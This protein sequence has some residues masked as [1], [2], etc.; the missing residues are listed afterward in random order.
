MFVCG[1]FCR[2]WFKVVGEIPRHFKIDFNHVVS[3]LFMVRVQWMQSDIFWYYY[4]TPA[5]LNLLIFK[6]LTIHE[7]TKLIMSA[8]FPHQY[9]RPQQNAPKIK[10]TKNNNNLHLRNTGLRHTNIDIEINAFRHTKHKHINSVRWF[11]RI[12]SIS[13]TVIIFFDNVRNTRHRQHTCKFF[14][15][16]S[17][18]A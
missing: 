13:L 18:Y 6:Y 15:A 8:Q 5:P 1:A 17:F 16:L 3:S 2:N 12:K 7:E 4:Q 11:D 10:T 9:K 14:Y